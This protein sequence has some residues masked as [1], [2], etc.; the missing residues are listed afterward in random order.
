LPEEKQTGVVEPVIA[1][2]VGN[3]LTVME[4]VAVAAPQ[5][6]SVDTA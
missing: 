4:P 5:P 3:A 2:V 6:P 1:E